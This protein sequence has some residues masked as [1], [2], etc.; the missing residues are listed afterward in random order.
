M[1]TCF[2]LS[3]RSK[4]FPS[5][6][7]FQSV[8]N[9]PYGFQDKSQITEAPAESISA[10]RKLADSC[11]RKMVLRRMIHNLTVENAVKMRIKDMIGSYRIISMRLSPYLYQ[12][13]PLFDNF[14]STMDKVIGEWTTSSSDT[15]L[16]WTRCTNKHSLLLEAFRPRTE[17][18]TT[19]PL[20]YPDAAL[21]V[22]KQWKLCHCVQRR[23]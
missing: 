18:S 8:I 10:A 13:H 19:P 15:A 5:V 21:S 17:S 11:S 3:E 23:L 9:D 4:M 6:R 12:G 1:F 7:K 2:E 14:V 22:N 20:S 16:V